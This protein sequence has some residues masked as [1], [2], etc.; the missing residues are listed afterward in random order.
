ME[1]KLVISILTIAAFVLSKKAV[2]LFKLFD[3]F[4]EMDV[5]ARTV[6]YKV[7]CYIV[8]PLL[9]TSLFHGFRNMLREAGLASRAREGILTGFVGTLP[10]LLGAGLLVNFNLTI[11][12]PSIFIGCLLAAVGE[13]LLYRA[14]L[15]G[16]LFRHARWG[17][18]PAGLV[19]AVV[20]GAGHLYQGTDLT[21]LIGVFAVTFMGGMWF[22]WL[23]VEN[24]YN[25]WVPMSYHFFMNLSWSIFEVGDNALGAWAP[26]IF[27]AA[28][29][30]LSVYLTFRYKKN[31]GDGWVVRGRRWWRDSPEASTKA[32][33]TGI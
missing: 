24:G 33:V 1:K 22:S 2:E 20:F 26:N 31:S 21:S 10:M 3:W 12:W 16:Q 9:V 4:I 13:E 7:S 14:M 27:R 32:E 17:F 30:A 28:T 23:Y 19:S 15:F 18:L 6:V 5:E 25:L 11:S 8:L 29:I